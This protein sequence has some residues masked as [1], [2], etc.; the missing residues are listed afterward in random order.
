[1]CLGWAT[2]VSAHGEGEKL[3]IYRVPVG[4]YY[5]SVWSLPGVLRTGEV[6]F[7]T[8]VLDQN[9]RPVT[10]CDVK[11]QLSPV[12]NPEKAIILQTRQPTPETLF[13]HEIEDNVWQADQ[14]H[15]TVLLADPAGYTG[16]VDFQVEVIELP[17]WLKIP[18]YSS[19]TIAALAALF[20]MQKGVVIFG[21][22]KPKTVQSRHLARPK[23]PNS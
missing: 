6:H 22:W 15:I 21:I 13:R 18:I 5:V 3:E 20:L 8:A 4:D 11:I 7:E 1:M 17:L 19:M 16:E 10:D 14:Y 23:R 9:Y 2:T 12:N